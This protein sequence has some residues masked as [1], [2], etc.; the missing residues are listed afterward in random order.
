MLKELD[1]IGAGKKG[2]RGR[3]KLVVI[4][5]LQHASPFFFTSE[6]EGR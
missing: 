6:G 2:Q 4:T 3:T 5:L 1:K